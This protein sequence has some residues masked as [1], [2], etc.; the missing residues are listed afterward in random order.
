MISSYFNKASAPGHIH[1]EHMHQQ[2]T[3]FTQ[4]YKQLK[5]QL[6]L[7]HPSSPLSSLYCFAG[8]YTLTLLSSTPILLSSLSVIL[9]KAQH[10]TQGYKPGDLRGGRGCL[11]LHNR[12]TGKA[13]GVLSHLDWKDLNWKDVFFLKC[14]FVI[15]FKTIKKKKHFY[16]RS[17]WSDQG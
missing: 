1:T 15:Q 17:L 12:L 5:E 13:R 2:T 3:T 16:Q 8:A 11:W 10:R 7:A 4:S 6:T 14:L 9:G